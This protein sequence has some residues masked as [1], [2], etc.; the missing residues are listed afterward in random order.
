MPTKLEQAQ[1]KRVKRVRSQSPRRAVS[2]AEVERRQKNP[3]LRDE[4]IG[5][6]RRTNKRMA[7]RY[8]KDAARA[9]R[10]DAEIKKAAKA[11]GAAASK[12]ALSGAGRA[13]PLVGAV[14]AGAKAVKD[15]VEP[16]ADKAKAERESYNKRASTS[17][18]KAAR[19]VRAATS[20]QRMKTLKEKSNTVKTKKR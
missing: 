7:E 6:E 19:G 8:Q 2:K 15:V 3:N 5:I 10:K 20:G 9:M 13:A 12:R 1:A 11:A 4:Q 18:A 17:Q 16:R 14:A